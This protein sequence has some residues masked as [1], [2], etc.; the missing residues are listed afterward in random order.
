MSRIFPIKYRINSFQ[1]SILVPE[2]CFYTPFIPPEFFQSNIEL[3]N[4]SQLHWF[5]GSWFLGSRFL[6]PRLPRKCTTTTSRR[7]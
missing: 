4:F 6:V 3:I 5:L 7:T 1:S 2:V